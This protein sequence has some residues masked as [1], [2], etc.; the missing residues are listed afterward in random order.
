VRREVE[1]KLP[2]PSI[3]LRN[4]DIIFWFFISVYKFRFFPGRYR[5]GPTSCVTVENRTEG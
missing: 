3:F 4:D 2:P 1:Q 5:G